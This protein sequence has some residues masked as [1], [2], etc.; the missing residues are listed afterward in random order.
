MLGTE[1]GREAASKLRQHIIAHHGSNTDILVH[2]F[3]NREGLGRALKTHLNIQP[4]T[5]NAFIIGFNTAS[6][7][8]SMLDVGVGKEAADVKIR[9]G[10]PLETLLFENMSN[11]DF[12][13]IE[14]MRMFVRYT[15][16]EYP[17]VTPRALI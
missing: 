7:C 13:F 6:P 12:T 11:R 14:L 2:V 1:G 3:F 10:Y 4:A 5:F 16:G 9:G 17:S 15:H 8:M